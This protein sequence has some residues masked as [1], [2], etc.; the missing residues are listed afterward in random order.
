MAIMDEQ[1]VRTALGI[2]TLEQGSKSVLFCETEL[3]GMFD[4]AAQQYVDII[5]ETGLRLDLGEV[6]ALKQPVL[7]DVRRY[8]EKKG[9]IK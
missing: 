2:L 7:D 8:L 9:M 4:I 3:P 6:K 1:A 5:G